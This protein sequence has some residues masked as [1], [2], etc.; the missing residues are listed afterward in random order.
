MTRRIIQNSIDYIEEHL[1]TDITAKELSEMAGF[2]LF[3]YYRLFQKAVGMPVMQFILR[4]KLLNAV[5]E[6]QCGAKILDTALMYGFETQ[7][8]FY[9]AFVREFGYTPSQFLKKYRIKKPYRINILK[10][11]QIMM[12]HK[13][14]REVLKYWG[15]E[16]EKLTDIVYDE[17]GNI[18]ESACYVGDDHVI[19]FSANAGQVEKMI[20]LTRAVEDVGISAAVPVET[21]DGRNYIMDGDVYFYVTRRVTG[22]QLKASSMYLEDYVGKARFIGEVI[23]QL[24][25]ALAHADVAVDD[26]DIY[27]RTTDWAIP[28]L[29]EKM[30]LRTNFMD[31]YVKVF[32]ELAPFLPRQIIHRDPNPGN[33]ILSEDKWGML[34]F[35][36]SERNVRILDPCYAASAILSESFVLGD[37]DRL[38]K[39]ISIYKNIIRGYDEVVKLTD[40]EYRA[41]PYVLLANQ[42]IATSWFAGQ[43]KYNELYQINL[44]MTEWMMEAFEELK[45]EEML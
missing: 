40:A 32:S 29:K 35:D 33:I 3:H 31:E 2:S 36:L 20:S 5:Y 15:L 25:I 19:K 23:G 41:V 11:E 14:L 44:N 45:M 21:M 30:S 43:E 9:K 10:E 28:I 39:W 6:I 26:V 1:K 37:R 38:E 12:T 7:A 8:G 34:D 27:R 18:N 42:L 4:R 16:K 22:T 17:T 24:S 13:R